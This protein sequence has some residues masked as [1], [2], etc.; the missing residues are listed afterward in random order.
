MRKDYPQLLPVLVS[1]KFSGFIKN[2][3]NLETTGEDMLALLD[4][5]KLDS[6]QKTQLL[7]ADFAVWKT[8][9]DTGSLAKIGK[10]MME[11]RF[12]GNCAIPI[13]S[14]I[15]SMASIADKINVMELQHGNTK[16]KEIARIVAEFGAGYAALIEKKGRS[17]KIEKTLENEKLAKVLGAKGLIS[18][19][20]SKGDKI[21]IHQRKK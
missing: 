8:M 9:T 1:V 13:N 3:L 11:I 4:S 15:G 14:I 5:G 12:S 17:S 19:S 2:D 20:A 7:L 18:S 6:R 10:A 16:T 21:E